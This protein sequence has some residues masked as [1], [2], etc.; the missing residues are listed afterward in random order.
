MAVG[1]LN[2]HV[3]SLP[4]VLNRAGYRVINSAAT[5]VISAEISCISR[6]AGHWNVKKSLVKYIW[7]SF[8]QTSKT[9]SRLPLWSLLL[10]ELVPNPSPGRADGCWTLDISRAIITPFS[11]NLHY[12]HHWPKIICLYVCSI[13]FYHTR[14]ISQLLRATV[15]SVNIF[16]YKRNYYVLTVLKDS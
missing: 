7:C 5:A 4:C 2:Y 13:K 8:G 3:F 6:W 15:P 1:R 12:V 9:E 16:K 11:I 14:P 10:F